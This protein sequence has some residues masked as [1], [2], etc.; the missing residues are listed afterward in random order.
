MMKIFGTIE[1]DTIVGSYYTDHFVFAGRG[2]DT[3]S[4]WFGDDIA[5]MGKG[6]D[7]VY[8][9]NRDSDVILF[10]GRGFD[11]LRI[12]ANDVDIRTEGNVTYITTDEG[13]TVR[14]QGFEEILWC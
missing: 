13:L 11:S 2:D 8:V 3:F 5:F 10:G 6:E 12:G 1:N 7:S 9:A 4:S 14:A